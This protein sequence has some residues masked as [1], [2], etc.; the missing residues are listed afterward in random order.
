MGLDGAHVTISLLAKHPNVRRHITK[1]ACGSDTLLDA[2]VT[3]L[4]VPPP[5]D[6]RGDRFISGDV[7]SY[8]GLFI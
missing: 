5:V 7:S 2:A 6:N 4:L 8:L 1:R 3:Q